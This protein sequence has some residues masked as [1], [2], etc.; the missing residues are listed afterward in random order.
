[1]L[2]GANAVSASLKNDAALSQPQ[3]EASTAAAPATAAALPPSSPSPLWHVSPRVASEA[4]A[5]LLTTANGDYLR[6]ALVL[7]TSI[8]TFDSARDLV[9]LVTT[10][11]PREWRSALQ[12]VGWNVVQAREAAAAHATHATHTRARARHT[13]TRRT[14]Y[15][16]VRSRTLSFRACGVR[17][18]DFGCACAC[19]CACARGSGCAFPCARPVAL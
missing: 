7:G 12:V 19:A 13:N 5:T 6:G 15:T 11:V 10:A 18:G 3:S 1:M 9:C 8:R 14:R 2:G 16:H 17:G 4:F